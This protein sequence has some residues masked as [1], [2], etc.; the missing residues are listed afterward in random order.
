MIIIITIII[1]III[2][3]VIVIVIIVIIVQLTNYLSFHS[4]IT[5]GERLVKMGDHPEYV[6]G[7]ACLP[8][9][10]CCCAALYFSAPGSFGHLAHSL[11]STVIEPANQSVQPDGLPVNPLPSWLVPLFSI[12]T[13]SPLQFTSLA[14]PF[15]FTFIF[16]FALRRGLFLE[17]NLSRSR[18]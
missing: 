6:I 12:L 9:L 17:D 7:I 13:H 14:L 11:G 2:V 5:I 1:I 8:F 16:A 4:V 10:S 3:F 15:T 18:S